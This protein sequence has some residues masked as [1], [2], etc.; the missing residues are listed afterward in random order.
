MP[1]LPMLTAKQLKK[2]LQHCGFVFKRQRGSHMFFE[3]LDGRTTVVPNHSGEQIDRSL[4]N[5]IIKYDLEMECGDFIKMT[6]K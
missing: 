2:I 1:R 5:K 4:L 3:H 6:I